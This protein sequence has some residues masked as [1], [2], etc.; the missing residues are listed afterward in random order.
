MPS[1]QQ[2]EWMSAPGESGGVFL[3]QNGEQEIREWL[4]GDMGPG[5]PGCQGIHSKSQV[6]PLLA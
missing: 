1:P 4:S 2:G 6:L 3:L 5:A